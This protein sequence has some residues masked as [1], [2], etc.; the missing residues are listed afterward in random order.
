MSHDN[1]SEDR[2]ISNQQKDLANST[3]YSRIKSVLDLF[4]AKAEHRISSQKNGPQS[5][6]FNEP[7]AQVLGQR[8][9]Q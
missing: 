2:T 6:I 1:N 5:L 8:G 4:K 7:I 9:Y 3:K